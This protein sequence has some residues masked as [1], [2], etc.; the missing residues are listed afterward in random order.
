MVFGR[1][2]INAAFDITCQQQWKWLDK[3]HLADIRW[4]DKLSLE[5]PFLKI[6]NPDGRGFKVCGNKHLL[7]TEGTS[8]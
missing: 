1:E 8:S 4:Q 7:K 2:Q 6:P 5:I 3:L